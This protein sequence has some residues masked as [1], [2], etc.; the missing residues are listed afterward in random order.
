M[1]GLERR[2]TN[3]RLGGSSSSLAKSMPS[4]SVPSQSHKMHL[5]DL[6][7]E[8]LTP[9]LDGLAVRDLVPCRQVAQYLREVIDGSERL[10]YKIDLA[11]A[12]MMDGLPSA[13]CTAERRNMLR[14]H[15][16]AGALW[17][18]LGT[19]ENRWTIDCA[20]SAPGFI[21]GEFTLNPAQDLLVVLEHKDIRAQIRVLSMLDG[22]AH[23]AAVS[24]FLFKDEPIY[25][26]WHSE[27]R[28]QGDAV[29][30]L[31]FQNIP[32][33]MRPR[34]S[35]R[36]W[37][38]KTGDLIWDLPVDQPDRLDLGP[39]AFSFLDDN[40]MVSMY[41][42]RLA[43][44]GFH[45]RAT[46]T[47]K[48]TSEDFRSGSHDLRDTPFESSPS[49]SLFVIE[50]NF[51]TQT[52]YDA[53]WLLFVLALTIRTCVARARKDAKARDLKWQA[54]GSEGARIMRRNEGA[55]WNAFDVQGT[56]AV[57]ATWPE[58]NGNMA[59]IRVFE[60]EPVVRHHLACFVELRST[61]TTGPK[62]ARLPT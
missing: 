37:D 5:Q 39:R 9:I 17:S 62:R 35:M 27:L 53:S 47:T 2:A 6:S 23:P 40:H 25:S 56:R 55:Q 54:W 59:H 7:V 38:W 45:T 48:A 61:R 8:V 49:E 24:A 33:R 58:N 46:K 18:F 29:G 4:D 60:F 34:S 1:T 11:V 22:T 51:G 43:V 21:M 15:Q 26:G 14:E 20:A 42:R 3:L 32:S 41:E 44:Y 13:L 12:G 50:I 31:I 19:G 16:K 28:T 30:W 57:A 52:L 10:Q 36:V